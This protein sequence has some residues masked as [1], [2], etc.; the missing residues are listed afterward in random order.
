M[1]KKLLIVSLMSYLLA[2]CNEANTRP[3]EGGSDVVDPHSSEGRAEIAASLGDGGPIE[4]RQG[5]MSGTLQQQLDQISGRLTLLQEQVIQIRSLSQQTLEQGQLNM[6]RLQ[7]LTE[8][9]AL[10][11]SVAGQ[12]ENENT[13]YIEQAVREI[14]SAVAQLLSA[15][16]MQSPDMGSVVG[17]YRI[18]TAYTRNGWILIRYHAESGKAWLADRGTWI[19]IGESG[20]LRNSIFEVQV[21]RADQ[22]V[23]GFVAVRIDKRDGRTWWLNDNTWQ[24]LN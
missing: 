6:S 24:A 1:L 11:P 18:S 12:A 4:V 21:Q 19:D 3:G 7:L 14:D 17:A 2:G 22:D 8:S 16:S 13:Q 15:L 23:K 10:G 20:T 9:R 5:D